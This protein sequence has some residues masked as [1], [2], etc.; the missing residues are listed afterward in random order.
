MKIPVQNLQKVNVFQQQDT[1]GTQKPG[2]AFLNKDDL[3]QKANKVKENSQQIKT[4]S[5][6]SVDRKSVQIINPKDKLLDASLDHNLADT[7][8]LLV[9]DLNYEYSVDALLKSDWSFE[10]KKEISKTEN[11]SCI[12]FKMEP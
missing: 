10:S 7:D 2:K 4:V 6:H 3:L 5:T 8:K 11:L 12:T 9:E 1:P